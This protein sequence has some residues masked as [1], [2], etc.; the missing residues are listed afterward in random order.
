[1]L[2]GIPINSTLVVDRSFYSTSRPHRFDIVLIR[3]LLKSAG[4]DTG[5]EIQVVARIIGLP[6]ET[7]ALRHHNIYIN[8]RRLTE[9]FPMRHC[10]GK[11]SALSLW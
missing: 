4:A 5:P 7:I 9:T 6:G 1:M 3:R 10:S 8:G 11:A 2:P